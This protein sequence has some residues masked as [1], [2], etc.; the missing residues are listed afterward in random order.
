MGKNLLLNSV[1]RGLA[2]RLYR[3]KVVMFYT[4]YLHL[5]QYTIT[6]STVTSHTSQLIKICHVAY[7][8]ASCESSLPCSKLVNSIKS[9]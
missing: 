9:R 6:S 4:K 8:L 5:Q 3:N 2:I 7:N 1:N